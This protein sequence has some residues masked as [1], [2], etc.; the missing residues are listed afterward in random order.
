MLLADG[1]YG[2]QPGDRFNRCDETHFGPRAF[3]DL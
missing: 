2:R 1:D 3:P